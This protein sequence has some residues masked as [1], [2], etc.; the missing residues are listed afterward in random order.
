MY[1]CHMQ[2][3]LMGHQPDVWNAVRDMA[4]ME[5]FTHTFLESDSP[6]EELAARANAIFADVRDMDET[7]AAKELI[8]W[9]KQRTELIL[10]AEKE[11]LETL[12]DC[13]PQIQDIWVL[14]RVPQ[15]FMYISVFIIILTITRL[16]VNKRMPF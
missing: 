1:H 2:I 16:C 8:S 9:K 7:H 6:Q 13:L 5:S 3:Y 10:L 11:Q 15:Y 14:P 12:L 4:P